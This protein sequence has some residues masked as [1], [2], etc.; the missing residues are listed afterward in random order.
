MKGDSPTFDSEVKLWCFSCLSL[1][2][3]ESIGKH[4]TIKRGRLDELDR[5]S[6]SKSYIHFLPTNSSLRK[7]RRFFALKDL[8]L[9]SFSGAWLVSRLDRTGDRSIPVSTGLGTGTYQP[10]SALFLGMLGLALVLGSVQTTSPNLGSTK[11]QTGP[12]G[13]DFGSTGI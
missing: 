9:S 5:V 10:S 8:R 3:F 13:Q 6:F 11:I 1:F 2:V 7:E 12:F 4:N